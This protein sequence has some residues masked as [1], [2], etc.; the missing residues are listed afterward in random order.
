VRRL[1]EQWATQALPQTG[2]KI[3]L[4]AGKAGQEASRTAF[5]AKVREREGQVAQAVERALGAS[6]TPRDAFLTQ[7]LYR[8]YREAAWIHR[9]G[10]HPDGEPLNRQ[11]R[12]HVELWEVFLA[13]IDARVNGATTLDLG[14][15]ENEDG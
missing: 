2:E 4:V 15:T 11:H 9:T 10:Q 13:A 12:W 8:F 1:A 14:D 7:L 3:T 6:Q 5:L